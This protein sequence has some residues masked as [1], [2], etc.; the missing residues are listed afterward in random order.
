MDREP[1]TMIGFASQ[2]SKTHQQN[3]SAGN[4]TKKH[5][6]G[7]KVDVYV[8]DELVGSISLWTLTRFSDAG[9]RV[10]P[11]PQQQGADKVASPKKV[12]TTASQKIDSGLDWAEDAN[13]AGSDAVA[14]RSKEP[15]STE[16]KAQPATPIPATAPVSLAYARPH[17]QKRTFQLELDVVEMPST[18]ALGDVVKWM[19]D[20]ESVTGKKLIDYGPPRLDNI[21]RLD[22]LIDLYQAALAFE[23]KP[24]AKG[25]RI[26]KEIC[27]RV[28][29]A[30]LEIT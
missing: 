13:A 4:S 9:K 18:K 8:G 1:A 21:Q 3:G 16:P 17:M 19:E 20:N 24:W 15:S 12:S 6:P 27:R 14:E 28:S 2:F 22:V 10:F 25:I 5:N 11:R 23:L 29:E 30:P 7:P 26:Q